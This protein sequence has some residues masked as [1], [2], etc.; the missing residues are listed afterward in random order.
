VYNFVLILT[1]YPYALINMS[2]SAGLLYIYLRPK[3]ALALGWNPPFRA[4]PQVAW[5]F[6]TSNVLLVVVPFIPPAPGYQVFERI[7]YYLPYVVAL[8]IGFLGV[9]YWY[10]QVV[11]LPRKGG[12]R[13]ETEE[14]KE[15]GV[16]RTV[17]R[18]VPL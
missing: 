9:L 6:F 2:I 5:I 16:S 10:V 15:D 4:H 11:Y 1:S 14:V 13:L 7:P 17:F 3:G 12:Y 8:M 18:R